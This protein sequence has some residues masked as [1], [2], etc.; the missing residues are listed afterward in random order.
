MKFKFVILT[1]STHHI[2]PA[3]RRDSRTRLNCKL[4]A[5][6]DWASGISGGSCVPS[7]RRSGDDSMELSMGGVIE[8]PNIDTPKFSNKGGADVG[9]VLH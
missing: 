3:H 2:P 7:S 5:L 4:T 9:V 1:T 8:L 6:L